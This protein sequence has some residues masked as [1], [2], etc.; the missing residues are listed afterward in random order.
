MASVLLK[1]VVDTGISA[2]GYYLIGYAF[3]AGSGAHPNGFI[4]DN[5]F[6]LT[7]MDFEGANRERWAWRSGF[8]VKGH[9][10]GRV[11]R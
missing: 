7:N 10:S 5:N 1:S 9:T 6:A 2:I 4:G 3:T 8:R 11:R